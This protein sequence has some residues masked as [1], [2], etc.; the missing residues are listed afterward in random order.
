MSKTRSAFPPMIFD[1]ILAESSLEQRIDQHAESG[2]IEGDHHRAVEIRA[3]RHT[4]GM[5]DAAKFRVAKVA[6]VV[7]G[8]FHARV[9]D[10]HRTRGDGQHVVD[11]AGRGV[12]QV[13]Q[14]VAGF[15]APDHFAALVR[16]SA[17]IH[18]RRRAADVV[19]EEMRGRH[20][21]ESG[22]VEAVDVGKVAIERVC[23][24]DSPKSWR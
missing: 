5:R 20:H 1:V 8:A 22:V 14:H 15:H 7:A 11:G 24:F 3:E 17:F 12:S 10:N 6:A 13:H 16:E 19:I 21:A 23:P 9:G 2:G 18:A 4:A